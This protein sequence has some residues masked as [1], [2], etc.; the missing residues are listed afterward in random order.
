MKSEFIITKIILRFLNQQK[1]CYW[2]CKQWRNNHK[3]SLCIVLVFTVKNQDCFRRLNIFSCRR[4]LWAYS[5]R[6]WVLSRRPCPV[7]WSCD[8]TRSPAA[9][10]CKHRGKKTRLSLNLQPFINHWKCWSHEHL[11]DCHIIPECEAYFNE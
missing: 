9:R 1:H 7:P 6:P 4:H 5:I 2:M 3:C 8:A 10:A 11:N